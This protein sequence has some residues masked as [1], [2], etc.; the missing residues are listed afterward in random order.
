MERDLYIPSL[1]LLFILTL[2]FSEEIAFY[3]GGRR[4]KLTIESTFHR[5]VRNLD[6]CNN[7]E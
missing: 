2:N 4:E 6:N 7:S 1:G 3:Q 5:L